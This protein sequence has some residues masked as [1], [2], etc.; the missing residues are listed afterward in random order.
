M[1]G[2]SRMRAA[3]MTGVI[4]AIALSGCGGGGGA[5]AE[6]TWVH[7][8]EGTIVIESGGSASITQSS[9]PIP[10]EWELDGDVVQFM[11]EGEDEVISEATI[12]GDSMTFRAGDFSGDDPVTFT[13]Q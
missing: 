1:K 10:L 7:E 12:D 5:D 4:G 8:E 11:F 9:D 13:R 2:I 6:G 3:I